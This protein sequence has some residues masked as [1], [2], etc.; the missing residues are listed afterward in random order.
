MPILS[1]ILAAIGS[2]FSTASA[3]ATGAAATVGAAVANTAVGS[4]AI[5][6]M[7]AVGSAVG[8]VAAAASNVP[9]IGSAAGAIA[10]TTGTAAGAAAVG[11]I[12]TTGVIGAASGMSGIAKLS[13]ADDIKDAAMSRYSLEKE[14]AESAEKSANSMLECLGKEKLS[15]W[16]SF[17]RF[18]TM[19]TKIQ[20]PPQM[21]GS[22]AE[23][24]L[25]LTPDEL[26]NIRAVAI[27]AKEMLIS[28]LGSAAAGQ[29]IGFAASGS[30]A[31]TITAASTGTAISS[32][33]GVAKKNA[34]LAALGGGTLD[35]G[36]AGI[37]GGTAVSGGLAFAPMLMVGGLALNE[38]ASQALEQAK[39]ISSEV[40]TA[41]S[42]LEAAE[43]NSEK[44]RQLAERIDKE[45]VAVKRVYL[46]LLEEMEAIVGRNTAYDKFSYKE[47]R[48][49]EKT[50]LSLKILKTLS[51][52]NILDPTQDCKVLD[53]EVNKA[54]QNSREI[55]DAITA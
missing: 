43:S 21:E 31:S 37:A 9:V 14:R 7:G 50:V 10:A 16:D 11:T 29:L 1:T 54:L 26:D 2:L 51:M 28:G 47:K 20:N 42:Q 8:T 53:A 33:S 25:A 34:I 49:L 45:L 6:S 40:D 5:S 30:L 4:A 36:G 55:M 23:E 24:S 39:D 41:I 46:E 44:V 22:A 32:L 48:T 17:E 27:S 19:Y 3:A 52:Q 35:L 13:E 18:S 38:K 12:T 15:I